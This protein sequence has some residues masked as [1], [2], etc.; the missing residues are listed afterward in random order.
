MLKLGR[1]LPKLARFCLLKLN[2]AKFYPFTENDE[3]L[4]QKIREDMVG[5]P[6]IV[7]TREAVVGKILIRDSTNWCKTIVGIVAK[8]L[9]PYSMSQAIPTDLYTRW[10]LNSEPGKIKRREHRTRSFENK[11]MSYFHRVGSQCKVESFYTTGT[12]KKKTLTALMVFLDG[13]TVCL[14]IW[15]VIIIIVQARNLVLLS[16]SKNISEVLK[17]GRD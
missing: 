11:V 17:R 5:G 6:S 2:N 8:S 4:L 3:N 12:Q 16:L 15:V 1:I 9:Y 14:K 13:A 10:E 7:F